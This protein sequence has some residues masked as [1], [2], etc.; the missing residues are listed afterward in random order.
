VVPLTVRETKDREKLE[1]PMPRSLTPWFDQY[2]AVHRP[3]LLRGTSES[4][5]W[6]SIRATA[7]EANSIY[8]WVRH[9]TGQLVG[10]RL[11]PRLFRDCVATFI[12]EEAPEDASIIARILGHSTLKTSEEYY[13]LA[14]MPRRAAASRRP[15]RE[16][17]RR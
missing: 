14:G 6:I 16:D 8:Y 17:S 2:F 7:T 11:N 9:V 3:L 5:M 10:Q 15:D 4:R 12:A 1:F 13:N